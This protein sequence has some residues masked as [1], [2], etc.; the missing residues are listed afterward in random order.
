[1]KILILSTYYYPDVAAIGI[2]MHH[3]SE[4][5]V[6]RGHSVTVI[7]SLPH[8]DKANVLLS[9]YS[10][11]RTERTLGGALTIHRVPVYMPRKKS[12][13]LG[14][15]LNFLGFT[16]LSAIR[17]LG[18]GK[19]DVILAVSPPLS[20][21]ITADLLSRLT[22]TPFVLNVQ[23]IWPD[24][25][26][27]A[28]AI[29]N[30]FLIS[31]AM[32]FERY[33]YRRARR[34]VVVS[35]N[36]RKTLLAK[37]LA[38]PV[39]VIENFCD[40]DILKPLTR[41]NE[42]SRVHGLDGSFVVLFAGNIGYSQGLET[43]IET[44]ELLRDLSHVVFVVVGNGVMKEKVVREARG[45]ALPNIR[46]LPFQPHE[47]VPA[48]YASADVCLVLLRKGFATYSEPSK[49][50]SIMAIGRPV[51]AAVDRESETWRL[52]QETQ[53]GICV[54]PQDSP[55]IAASIRELLARPELRRAFGRNGRSAIVNGYSR[56]DGAMKYD[57]I[58]TT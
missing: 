16:V 46:F 26:I 29:R 20:N 7:T 43:L 52:I 53:C 44:A 28:G 14:R 23:D 25:V 10:A 2:I 34:I 40:T 35:Q 6:K 4:D 21:G 38:T 49:I 5:L 54:E 50:L 37:K 47:D 12:W 24:V 9:I 56:M 55:G 17:A 48:V 36:M 18:V 19:H 8:Y 58:L 45:R 30:P 15:L 39:E 31:A 33:V 3:L 13:V 11:P 41:N 27:G 51:V 32:R 22:R 57:E 1:M 42:F